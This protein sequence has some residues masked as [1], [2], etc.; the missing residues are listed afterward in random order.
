MLMAGY[1]I[2]IQLENKKLSAWGTNKIGL[3]AFQMT[4]KKSSQLRWEKEGL[5]Q[6]LEGTNLPA[7]RQGK[8]NA[9]HFSFVAL[10]LRG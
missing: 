7:G 6:R 10:C 4:E 1:A 2:D 5:T 9:S 3:S 8:K